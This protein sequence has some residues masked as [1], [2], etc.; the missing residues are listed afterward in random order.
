MTMRTILGIGMLA[1][2]AALST[3]CASKTGVSDRAIAA[4]PT[5]ELQTTSMRHKEV[6]FSI[7]YMRNA[8]GRMFWDDLGRTFY[9]DQPSRL[10]PYPIMGLN[11]QPR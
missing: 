5:P 4:H 10:S 6:D 3:G 7:A 8:N 9:W 11:G 2:A 1:V